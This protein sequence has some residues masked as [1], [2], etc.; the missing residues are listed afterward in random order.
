VDGLDVLEELKRQKLK[1]MDSVTYAVVQNTSV[2][3]DFAKFPTD[4]EKRQFKDCFKQRSTGGPEEVFLDFTSLN[5]PDV[6][7]DMEFVLRSFGLKPDCVEFP[8][9]KR[10][11]PS[12]KS[13]H[14]PVMTRHY[15]IS[16]GKVVS[17]RNLWKCD[18]T[19]DLSLVNAVGYHLSARTKEWF[20]NDRFTAF[21][22]V[23]S[24]MMHYPELAQNAKFMKELGCIFPK[25]ADPSTWTEAGLKDL[26][27]TACG[28]LY[29]EVPSA[30][31]YFDLPENVA[32]VPRF[33][34][35][36]SDDDIDPFEFDYE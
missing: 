20:G 1:D 12:S 21:H 31:D 11:R 5:D 29:N 4:E 33:M 35:R 13:E 14:V 19:V 7:G 16:L 15:G 30:R 18:I 9:K 34:S 3:G 8:V 2:Y 27:W 10:G 32:R 6:M 23:R 28:Y 25:C 26:T 24:A 22:K 36:D 17:K